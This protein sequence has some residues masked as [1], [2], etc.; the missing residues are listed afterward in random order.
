MSIQDEAVKTAMVRFGLV[1]EAGV[2]QYLAGK[3][4]GEYSKR[5]GALSGA[6]GGSAL[7]GVVGAGVGAYRAEP[8][9][10]LAGALKGGLGGAVVGGATGGVAGRF[11]APVALTRVLR[12]R[13]IAGAVGDQAN[14]AYQH[15][16]M[17]R[18]LLQMEG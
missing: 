3:S 1:K 7:G 6:L 8:G 11:V 9:E 15:L 17:S 14:D 18:A 2:G 10:R 16:R 5:M 4:L 13:G 12:N